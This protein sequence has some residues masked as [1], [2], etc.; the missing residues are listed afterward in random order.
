[1]SDSYIQNEESA[2]SQEEMEALR[3][4]T[5]N[6]YKEQI[7]HL[8]LAAKYHSLLAEIQESKWREL[9]AMVSTAELT[10]H[11]RYG[12]EKSEPGENNDPSTSHG[13]P[14]PDENVE[15]TTDDEDA[16][17]RREAVVRKLKTD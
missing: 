2:M 14:Y 9:R 13:V 10:M 8:E 17:N 4:K 15:E 12:M 11:S 7:P 3:E 16:E 1:M 5:L 6:F